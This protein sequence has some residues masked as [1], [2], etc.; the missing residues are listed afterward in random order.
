MA[1]NYH[2]RHMKQLAEAK[3][4][5]STKDSADITSQDEW[6]PNQIVYRKVSAVKFTIHSMAEHNSFTCQLMHPLHHLLSSLSSPPEVVT[7]RYWTCSWSWLDLF[8]SL[9]A[10][11]CFYYSF[12]RVRLHILSTPVYIHRLI[13][14]MFK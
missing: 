2:R 9:R 3:A 10:F 7:R 6:N 8:S 4:S 11:P 12:S 14:L 13:T 5:E 1:S